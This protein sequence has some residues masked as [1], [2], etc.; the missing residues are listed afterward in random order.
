MIQTKPCWSRETGL[1]PQLSWPGKVFVHHLNADWFP[2]TVAG[3]GREERRGWW[4]YPGLER[5]VN[6]QLFWKLDCDGGTEIT[7][8]V[9]CTLLVR[10]D[11]L[12][13]LFPSSWRGVLATLAQFLCCR[14]RQ[15][16]QKH[17][18][19][20]GNKKRIGGRWKRTG[21]GD[22]RLGVEESF[23]W[24]WELEKG[25]SF[26]EATDDHFK[27]MVR[28]RSNHIATKWQ[29]QDLEPVVHP[30]PQSILELFLYPKMKPHSLYHQP[31]S[32]LPHQPK[33]TTNLPSVSKHLSV[34][35]IVYK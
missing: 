29:I 35:D 18:L 34:L 16:V 11:F 22:F 9:S 28:G 30:S 19:D 1:N 23:I 32:L 8:I 2:G 3:K 10:G 24:S 20:S 17:K 15:C 21:K 6:L 5:E 4:G 7:I 13:W 27:N 25:K 31:Q 14:V 33:V 12:R 26:G